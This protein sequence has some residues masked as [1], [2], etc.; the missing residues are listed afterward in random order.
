VF[1][2]VFTSLKEKNRKKEEEK[3]FL[4]YGFSLS[5]LVRMQNPCLHP[6]EGNDIIKTP[7]RAK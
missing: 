6:L 7:Q 2:L 5:N 4:F 1:I 3:T